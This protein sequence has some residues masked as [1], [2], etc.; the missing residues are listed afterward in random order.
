[1]KKKNKKEWHHA[2]K[3]KKCIK[4]LFKGRGEKVKFVCDPRI[5]FAPS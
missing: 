2:T 3:P 4:K 1:M 5:C